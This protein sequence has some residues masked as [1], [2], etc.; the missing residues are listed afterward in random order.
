MNIMASVIGVRLIFSIFMALVPIA[1]LV[2]LQVWLC[3]K[4]K[5]LGIILPA[6]S[7]LMSLLLVFSV[8]TITTVG[9]GAVKVYDEHGQLVEQHHQEGHREFITPGAMGA[10]AGVFLVSN[11]PT[12]A[13][14][15][16]WLHYKTRR[17]VQNDLEKM[18]IEDLE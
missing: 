9:S 15:G 6:L 11:I 8:A 12:V 1:L 14:G 4:S 2:V 3:K 10:V 16:I 5:W 13:F 17:D 7:L 18:K